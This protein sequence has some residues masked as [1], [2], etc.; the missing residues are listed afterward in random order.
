[1]VGCDPHQFPGGPVVK[2]LTSPPQAKPLTLMPIVGEQ[3]PL[4]SQES[5]ITV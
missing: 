5:T 2:E 1:M 4:A 3:T